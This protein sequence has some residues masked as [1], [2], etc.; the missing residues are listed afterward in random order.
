MK[1]KCCC[2]RGN[3]AVLVVVRR[4]VK[5]T[6]S[7]STVMLFVDLNT[8]CVVLGEIVTCRVV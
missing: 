2:G 5:L 4:V 3:V 6:R 7:G 8:V 1:A